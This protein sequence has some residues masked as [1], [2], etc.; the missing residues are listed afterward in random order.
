MTHRGS[1]FL[2]LAFTAAVAAYGVFAAGAGST[3]ARAQTG[4]LGGGLNVSVGYVDSLR[5]NPNLPVPW[6]GA[7]NTTFIGSAAPWDAGAIRLDNTTAN[8]IS[9]T[10]VQVNVNG[11]IFDLWPSFTIAAG[12]STILT[13]TTPYNFDTSDLTPNTC[14]GAVRS[15][16]PTI[17]I[18]VAGS[19]STTLSDTA[20]ILDTFGYDLGCRGN[21]SLQWR[22]VGLAGGISA[23]L[24]LAPPTATKVIGT[25]D[26]SIA[27]LTDA[28]GGPLANVQ[29]DFR[30]TGGPDAGKTG[31]VF[32]DNAGHAPF[33]YTG[34]HLGLDTVVA[35]VTN[36]SGG[37]FASNPVTV[38]WVHGAVVAYTGPARQDYNDPA[39]VNATLKDESGKPIAN[40]PVTFI[41]GRSGQTCTGKTDQ[42]GKASCTITPNEA[43]GPDTIKVEYAGDSEHEAASTSSPFTVTLEEDTLDSTPHLMLLAQGSTVT[44]SATLKEDGTTPIVGRNVTETVGSGSNSQSCTGTTDT[45]GT[46]TCSI[47]SLAVPLGPQPVTDTFA[48]DGYYQ[49][50]THNQHSLV[51]AYL[52]SGSFVVGDKS[53]SMGASVTWWG[54]QWSKINNLS[55]GSA[56]NAFKGFADTLDSTPPQ[57]GGHWTSDPGRSSRPP[58][59]VPS[60]MAVISS[61]SIG[62][63]GRTIRGDVAHI[64]IVKTNSGYESNPGHAGTGTVVAQ[65]CP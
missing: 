35:S 38:R 27:T 37:N 6:R 7:P 41:L 58:D 1:R 47:S 36:A 8:P 45:T 20:H 46:A 54:A 56:P 24:T 16:P 48:S 32:T 63:S 28:A 4:T 19:P 59:S 43:A 14:G 64:V 44:L 10:K 11:H 2:Q 62:K 33:T 30:V 42:Q 31:Q 57:C 49:S 29:I 52:A 22:T 15:N 13:Q 3:P 51:F 26:T 21:E 25:P 60:Y 61:S 39:T 18:S 23:R 17:T 40:A 12:K 55:G 9:V 50:Q 34:T 65:L 5:P 53:D